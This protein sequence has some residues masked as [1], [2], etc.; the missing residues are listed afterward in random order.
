MV[1]TKDSFEVA[2]APHA[3]I[4]EVE[5]ATNTH[6]LEST[7]AG[8]KSLRYNSFG[9]GK[10]WLDVDGTL[11]WSPLRIKV[12]KMVFSQ[13]FETMM[14][15]V[16]VSNLILIWFEADRD[17]QC[18]PTFANNLQDC[19]HRSDASSWINILNLILL[20]TYTFECGIRFFVERTHYWY[21]AWNMIDLVTMILGWL[22]LILASVVNLSLLRLTR[23]VRVVRAVRVFISVPEFYLLITGLYSSI[24]AILFGSMMLVIVILFWA[25]IAVE[26]LHPVVSA[27]D[28][29]PETCTRC[30][31]SFQDVASAGVT[32]FQQIV[33]GDSWGEI[34][35]PLIEANPLSGVL[36]FAVMIFVGLGMMN[37]ILAVIVER[38]T[39]ARENDHEQKIKKKEEERSKS[40]VD[41]AKLCASMDQNNNG[42]VSL[43][44]M[45][46]GYDQLESFRKLMQQMDIKRDEMQTVFSVLD[47]DS[48]GE[49]S[50]L[51]F[52]QNIG[53]FLKRDPI[54][55]HS[56]VHYSVLE[57]RKLIRDEVMQTLHDQ[58]TQVM[59][60][61]NRLLAAVGLE[62]VRSDSKSYTSFVGREKQEAFARHRK[63][64]QAG[65]GGPPTH[66][67]LGFGKSDLFETLEKMEQE[68][69]PLL[70]RAQQIV[71]SLVDKASET[72]QRSATTNASNALSNSEQLQFEIVEESADLDSKFQR[73]C[74]R[75]QEQ[76]K[77]A[78]LLQDHLVDVLEDLEHFREDSQ[79]QGQ[80]PSGPSTT[81]HKRL[82]HV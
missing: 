76:R 16:I 27:L 10:P 74:E 37:L 68:L 57:L 71:I 29:F 80:G 59:Q 66:N 61:Q 24:K 46:N 9:P 58:H 28:T 22:S 23:L 62:E 38:A 65:S 13:G 33:A 75:F 12:A 31:R 50:Y 2:A 18:Y 42:L 34:S 49:V 64:S 36:L 6:H 15:A 47:S 20:L 81:F 82:F 56:L 11:I 35:V 60:A 14:G 43:Q 63:S 32:F 67:T 73:L 3:A 55:M 8:L 4:E 54:I 26:L 41:L 48:S 53:G 69:Q 51:E 45:Q 40:M 39:E 72:S 25:V 1:G 5:N 78:A 7:L 70:D 44:E 30:Q 79:G 19:P 17:A 77:A 21:N 52:C